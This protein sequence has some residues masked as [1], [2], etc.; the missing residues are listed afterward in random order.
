MGDRHSTAKVDLGLL[1]PNF[2]LF[3]NK[4]S[5]RYFSLANA[6][7]PPTA[8]ASLRRERNA[9]APASV[10][11]AIAK[12][13]LFRRGGRRVSCAGRSYV[14]LLGAPACRCCAL[15]SCRAGAARRG[16]RP[17][18]EHT[19]RGATDGALDVHATRPPDQPRTT[20][21]HQQRPLGGSRESTC[22]S[23]E[24]REF[25]CGG[26]ANCANFR[27]ANTRGIHGNTRGIHEIHVFCFFIYLVHVYDSGDSGES[28]D[29][30]PPL[31][32]HGP[33]HASCL[34]C[35]AAGAAPL[36][37]CFVAL[38]LLLFA[39]VKKGDAYLFCTAWRVQ[40]PGSLDEFPVSASSLN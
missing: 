34:A 32:V 35:C 2:P 40:R 17:S 22:E 10:A 28:G 11:V 4:Q 31:R 6:P 23:R 29:S 38:A 8:R 20:A 5:Q 18:A 30:P 13:P 15:A 36:C 37:C 14:V 26:R 24:S 39:V 3:V 33:W 16:E 12:V 27:F 1:T 7:H 21:R 25:A 19:R 9:A